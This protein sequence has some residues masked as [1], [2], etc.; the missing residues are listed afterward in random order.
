MFQLSEEEDEISINDL[1]SDAA[2]EDSSEAET[3]QHEE[4]EDLELPVVIKEEPM[5]LE[6]ESAP[7]ADKSL[8]SSSLQSVACHDN[9]N[10]KQVD[11]MSSVIL[12][13]VN[14]IPESPS[15]KT[16]AILQSVERQSPSGVPVERQAGSS[17]GQE[18]TKSAGGLQERL[19]EET[20]LVIKDERKY[21][22]SL[23]FPVSV[24]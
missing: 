7:A 21:F 12:P 1:V 20:E 24:I 2:N 16:A 22:G 19:L 13:A 6:D 14:S 18:A 17:A 4:E 9:A 11:S 8:K 5:D 15:V 3:V 10:T 23:R